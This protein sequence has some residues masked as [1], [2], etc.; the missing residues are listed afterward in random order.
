MVATAICCL[1]ATSAGLFGSALP[2][3]RLQRI[4][5]SGVAGRPMRQVMES[6]THPVLSNIGL[7]APLTVQA[8]AL[9]LS[10]MLGMISREACM[11]MSNSLVA[12]AVVRNDGSRTREPG[13]GTPNAAVAPA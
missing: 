9:V 3:I 10:A 12:P 6:A 11:K 2:R 1:F 7:F 5:S 4:T 8:G 13:A